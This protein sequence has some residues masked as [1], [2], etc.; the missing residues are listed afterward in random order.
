VET[1]GLD[2]EDTVPSLEGAIL[3]AA[4]DYVSSLD[5]SH[6]GV[7]RVSSDPSDHINGMLLVRVRHR[8][9]HSYSN[10]L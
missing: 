4:V 9:H 7:T 8:T 10:F 2:P 5:S 3:D 1:S 6:Y